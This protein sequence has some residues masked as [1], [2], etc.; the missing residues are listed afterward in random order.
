MEPVRLWGTDLG[1]KSCY[2]GEALEL[3]L[4]QSADS[5]ADGL[6][7]TLA[8][9]EPCP[10]LGEVTAAQGDVVLFRGG[11]DEQR[12][13]H[14]GR[15]F[16]LEVEARGVGAGALDNEA[17][18][19]AY[20]WACLGEVFQKHA[21]PYGLTIGGDKNPRLWEFA[22][23]K[24]LSEWEVVESFCRQ[25]GLSRPRWNGSQVWVGPWSPGRS[26][27]SPAPTGVTV[28]HRRSAVLSH[29]LWRTG[30][31]DYVSAVQSP[32]AARLGVLRKRYLTPGAASSWSGPREG[33]R[34]LQEGCLGYRT[35]ELQVAGLWGV[36]PLDAVEAAHPLVPAGRWMVWE[37]R[38]TVDKAGARTS[39]VL[40]DPAYYGQ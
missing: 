8:R 22:V 1:G 34:L 33:E 13:S 25:A 40:A 17:R 20:R 12:A 14:T 15:G 7:A 21:A 6:V 28:T 16:L 19:Q 10:E 36:A 38:R 18:P 5:P 9:R 39:L 3:E 29:V 11:V 30:R 24:G 23:T 2:L 4:V 37:S 31:N 35:V 32:L 27:Q 26:W